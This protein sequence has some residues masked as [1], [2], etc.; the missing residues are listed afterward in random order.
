MTKEHKP[1]SDIIDAST[2]IQLRQNNQPLSLFDCRSKLGEPAWGPAA[3]SAGHIEGAQF[4]SLDEDLA[5][6]PNEDGRHPLPTRDRWLA[7]VRSKGVGQAH[8]IVLYDDAGG[9]Y[10]ARA[11]WMFRWLGHEAVAVVDGG[12][13]AWPQ[14]LQTEV[15]L[16]PAP[17]D[18]QAHASLT[19]MITTAELQSL[20]DSHTLID[21]RTQARYNGDEEPIDPVAGHIP[22]AVCY[23]FAANLG[24]SGHF[25]DPQQLRA[26]FSDVG[27]AAICY[28]GSGVTACHN[29]LAMHIAGLPEPRLY[30]PSWSGWITDAARPV[31]T[32]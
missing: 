12:L 22:G 24:A 20:A 11:W 14:P 3:F 17:S 27:E 23:P 4:L 15:S 19:R 29:I 26:R 10:A 18:Y 5:D 30:A 16:A 6:P 25:L 32:A 21:A 9:A 31:G 7:T 13:Q 2:L 8:Q 28:C 1:L